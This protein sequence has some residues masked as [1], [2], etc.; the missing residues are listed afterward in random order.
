MKDIVSS[1]RNIHGI[2]TIF[3]R[4]NPDE[5]KDY[6]GVLCDTPNEEREAV[7]M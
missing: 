4:Y 2:P 6:D 7:L 3:I 1:I 5:Y